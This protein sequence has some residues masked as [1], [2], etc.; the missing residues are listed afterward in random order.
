VEPSASVEPSYVIAPD[1]TLFVDGLSPLIGLRGSQ[2]WERNCD[3]T[4]WLIPEV[5]ATVPPRAACSVA[6][7]D[8]TAI[9]RW[10]VIAS[11]TDSPDPLGAAVILTR[12]DAGPPVS[13][14]AFEGPESGDWVVMA[15]LVAEPG[16]AA[17]FW[18]L[19]VS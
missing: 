11:P 16:D 17:Y 4:P 5:A 8:S 10:S 15:S 2:C 3:D 12:R 9:V 13:D 7:A 18:R 6:F 1:G 14:V 19:S